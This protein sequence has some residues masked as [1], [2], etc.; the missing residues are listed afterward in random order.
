MSNAN[1]TSTPG[2]AGHYRCVC[3]VSFDF[4]PV[5]GTSCPNCGRHY[6]PQV[7]ASK[8]ADTMTFASDVPTRRSSADPPADLLIGTKQGHY[9]IVS[10]LGEG[11][12]GCVYQAV[13]E[14]L[15]RYVALKV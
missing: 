9:R 8:F 11:G 3:G 4:N 5:T 13:D 14:S 1:P 15:Q 7:F 6:D 2:A 12:M 10:V